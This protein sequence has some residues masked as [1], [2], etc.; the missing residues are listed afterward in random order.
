[1]Q[2]SESLPAETA[3]TRPRTRATRWLVW[4]GAVCF[5]VPLAML[6]RMANLF[7]RLVGDSPSAAVEGYVRR[8]AVFSIRVTVATL[9]LGVVLVIL[10]FIIRRPVDK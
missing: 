7:S 10:G 8:N 2:G 4:L 5:F 1:M 3:K 9:V 6:C